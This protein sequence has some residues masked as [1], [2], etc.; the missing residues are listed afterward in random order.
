MSERNIRDTLAEAYDLDDARKRYHFALAPED[1]DRLPFYAALLRELESDTLALELLA[2]VRHEQRNPMLVLAALHLA[3]LTGHDVLGPIYN[4]ARHGAL[5][6]PDGA[7]RQVMD[8]VRS[9]PD[10]VRG[11][12][13]RSTQTNEP[14]RSAVIQAVMGD[15]ARVA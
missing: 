2:S 15:L 6:D 12:L 5:E 9:T 4:D 3:S 1:Y 13:W 11:Q 14:G 10:I 7:A 8:V